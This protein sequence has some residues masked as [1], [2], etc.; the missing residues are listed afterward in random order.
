[1]RFA[2]D[3]PNSGEFGD[4]GVLVGLA[5]EAEDAGWDGFF[6]WDHLSRPEPGP[7]TDPWVVLS[8]IAATTQ[9]IRLG[10][11]VSA[12]ARRRVSKLARETVALDHLSGGRLVLGVGLGHF[13]HEEF[14]AFGDPADRRVRGRVLDE[15][16]AALVGLWSGEP[17]EFKGEYVSIEESIFLPMPMQQPRIPIWVAGLWPNQRPMRRAAAWDGVFPIPRDSD[18]SVM[19]SVAETADVMAFVGQ[20]RTSDASFDYVHAGLMRGDP[21]ADIETAA[22]Y[23]AVGV[24]WWLEHCYPGRLSLR[25]LRELIRSG[26]PRLG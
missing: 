6:I 4:P 26:P 17:F 3:V 2:I 13:D 9:T 25:A 20:A 7:M 18:L 19:L 22:S 23:A 5:R 11:M 24:T 12:P 16:L 14:G 15:S 1:M 10:P 8:A 21:A